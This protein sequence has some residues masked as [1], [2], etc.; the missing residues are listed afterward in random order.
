MKHKLKRALCIAAG[1]A[2]TAGSVPQ[3]F[4]EY[5]LTADAAICGLCGKHGSADLIW[6]LE[7]GV[8]TIEGEGDMAQAASEAPWYEYRAE[9]RRVVIKEG[10]KS[11][12]RNAFNGCSAIT[13]VTIPDSVTLIGTNAFYGCSALTEVSI[14]AR[15]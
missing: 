15:V 6:K 4:P 7:D 13:E 9:I 2:L 14:P 12:E 10:V 5:V 8:L 3:L 1:L 11:I